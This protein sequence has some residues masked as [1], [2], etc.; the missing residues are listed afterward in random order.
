[1]KEILK[2]ILWL[3]KLMIPHSQYQNQSL[4]IILNQCHPPTILSTYFPK[5]HFNIII[6]FT[7]IYLTWLL[8]DE[9]SQEKFESISCIPN[10]SHI[11]VSKIQRS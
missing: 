8:Y 1:M 2:L 10:S 4:D 6:I 5:I 9:I 3:Y 7:Y 11:I